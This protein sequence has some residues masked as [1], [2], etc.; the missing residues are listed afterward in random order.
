[1]LQSKIWGAWIIAIIH[2]G[3]ED[4]Y[5]EWASI[6][7]NMIEKLESLDSPCHSLPAS[8]PQ[9]YNYLKESNPEKTANV[10]NENS[11]HFS[12]GILTRGVALILRYP[13][14]DEEITAAFVS[15][16]E[17]C[18]STDALAVYPLA[19]GAGLKGSISSLREPFTETLNSAV[20]GENERKWLGGGWDGFRGRWN[21]WDAL[22]S[23][24]A[25]G[26]WGAMRR[27][28]CNPDFKFKR[29]SL[30]RQLKSVVC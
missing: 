11:N 25:M 2:K 14:R 16:W 30:L 22:K 29:R 6:N 26:E 21:M 8:V 20:K 1:M 4:G 5:T 3:R 10:R 12:R 19:A 17:P 27:Q 23:S 7:P 9:N 24:S 15:K 28:P 13:G 18:P